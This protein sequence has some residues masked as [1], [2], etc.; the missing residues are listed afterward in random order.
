M[1]LSVLSTGSGIQEINEA[2][3]TPSSRGGRF[4]LLYASV[5]IVALVVVAALVAFPSR[6]ESSASSRSEITTTAS[7]GSTS[8]TNAVSKSFADHML[9]LSTGNVSGTVSQFEGNATVTWLGD[10]AG[11]TGNYIGVKNILLLMNSSFSPW[12]GSPAITNLTQTTIATSNH[13]AVVNSSFGYSGQNAFLGN[14]SGVITAEDYYS[15]SA[16]NGAW[17]IS[18]EI[19][20]YLSFN[21]EFPNGPP[22]RLAGIQTVQALGV[23]ADGDYVAAGA[24]DTGGYNGSV[25]LVSLQNQT[26]GVLWR[27]VTN[28]TA[29]GSV[30]ISSNGSYI[31]AAGEVG[32]GQAFGRGPGG[33]VNGSGELFVFNREGKLLWS[34]VAARELFLQS[35]VMSADGSRIAVSYGNIYGQSGIVCFNNAGDDLW[36]Y[37]SPVGGSIG[38]FAMSSDGGSITY[39]E[40][41][42]FFLNSHGHQVWNYT[43]ESSVNFIQISSDGA[44]V[45]V[46]TLSGAYNGSVLYFDGKNG[47]LLWQRQVYTEVQ[48]VV[49]SSDGSRI[50]IG[51]NTGV[52]L[53]DSSGNL[54]WNDSYA[55][56]SGN[57]VAILQSNSLVLLGG[58][59]SHQQA[60]LIGYNG[61][62]VASFP[63]PSLSVVAG[64]ANGP[65]WAAVGGSIAGFGVCATLH[66]FDGADALPSTPL[67]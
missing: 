26:E 47:V 24:S 30:A 21:I 4:A 51:G 65:A 34:H 32:H 64:S 29:I 10:A 36:N 23:S 43:K 42:I 62:T 56:V 12:L 35:V 37:T 50:A 53:L 13:S 48:P 38:H 46:G 27:Y 55:R 28:G 61:T 1:L 33:P 41:G 19:W 18:R 60:E 17:L 66:P 44:Y 52:M 9:F 14:F 57:P 67:C 3:M 6:S 5:M 45:A 2:N 58:E 59:Y 15:Y 22:E 39:A 7:Y 8:V 20:D 16:A 54:L 40:N 31:A 49:M 63:I 11:L 25:Y